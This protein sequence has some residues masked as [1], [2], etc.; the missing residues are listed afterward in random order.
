MKWVK[1]K[2]NVFF[3]KLLNKMFPKGCFSQSVTKKG[4]RDHSVRVFFHMCRTHMLIQEKSECLPMLYLYHLY[5]GWSIKGGLVFIFVSFS[6]S[7]NEKIAIY[8]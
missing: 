1:C 4:L 3:H 7:D 8:R 6:L 2:Q 5:V